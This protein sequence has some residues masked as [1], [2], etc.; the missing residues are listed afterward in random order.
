[1]WV[2]CSWAL[3]AVAWWTEQDDQERERAQ[4]AELMRISLEEAERRTAAAP[5]LHARSDAELLA[6][7]AGSALLAQVQAKPYWQQVLGFCHEP[8]AGR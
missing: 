4:L 1:M 8:I 5:P 2:V 6:H 7:F 3:A